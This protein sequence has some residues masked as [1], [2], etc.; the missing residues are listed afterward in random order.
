VVAAMAVNT[1]EIRRRT[2]KMIEINFY[3]TLGAFMTAP[4]WILSLS[5]FFSLFLSSFQRA[6][7]C[8]EEN[9]FGLFLSLSLF[10]SFSL[11]LSLSFIASLRPRKN[12]LGLKKK[13]IV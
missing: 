3:S 9:R 8:E 13:P 2:I 5:I 4:I 11:S 6:E 12:A 7:R 10:L 1:K